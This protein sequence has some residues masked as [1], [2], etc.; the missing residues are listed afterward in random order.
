[1]A[2]KEVPT[3][4]RVYYKSMRDTIRPKCENA[5]DAYEKDIVEEKALYDD[6]KLKAD[7]YKA[8]YKID[9]FSFDEFVNNTYID[10]KFYNFA[11]TLFINR[12]SKYIATAELYQLYKFA[13]K[14]KDLYELKH[15]IDIW[16][17]MLDLSIAEYQEVL[18][19]FYTEVHK[20]LIIDGVGYVFENP[21]GWICINRCK[22][23]KGRRKKLNFQATKLNKEKLLAEGKRLWNKDEAEYAKLI[24]ADYDGVDYRVYLEADACYEMPLINCNINNERRFNITPAFSRRHVK[25]KTNKQLI[26]ECNRDLNKICEL[27]V[28]IRLKLNLCLE[29][30]NILY[31]NFIR[32]EAQQSA[33]TPKANR[34][35]R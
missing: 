19:S 7:E 23:V 15:Q 21:I 5:R 13:K 20:K 12:K 9:L 29:T 2:I 18:Q 14:Q 30:D 4:L 3:S 1:M 24:G 34:K 27:P 35:N 33:H 32:N 10:G 11:K 17:R 28:D 31:L 26:E 6:I 25:G 16:E 22:I 8:S